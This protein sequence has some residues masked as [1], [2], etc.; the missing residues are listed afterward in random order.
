[1]TMHI[2]KTEI[3]LWQLNLADFDHAEVEETCLS[4]LTEPELQRY[5]RY[6]FDKHRKQLLLGRVL[7][8]RVLSHYHDAIA[9]TD[10]QFSY[11]AYGKPALEAAQNVQSL[12][13]NLSHSGARAVIAVARQGDIGVDVEYAVKP[14]R[15]EAIAQRY[16]SPSEAAELL[17]LPAAQQQARFYDLWTLKEAYIKACGMGLAIPLQHFS[18]GFEGDSRLSIAFDAEREDS[19]EGWQFWQ[20]D[21]TPDYRLALASKTDAKRPMQK[22]KGWHFS[23]LDSVEPLEWE[24]VR[25]KPR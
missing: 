24:I 7:L 11:N 20:L 17:A 16:F 1:M 3:H 19:E 18:Y 12:S 8:R 13:F 2:E 4:W 6:Q 10:W 23:A 14:R 15:I 22:I 9:P 21:A 5:R 25:S